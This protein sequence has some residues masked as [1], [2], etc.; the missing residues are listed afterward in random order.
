MTTETE[1]RPAETST[2]KRWLLYKAGK[3]DVGG[4]LIEQMVHQGL[5]GAIYLTP[6]DGLYWDEEDKLGAHWDRSTAAAIN[7]LTPVRVSIK[8]PDDCH[9]ALLML[10]AGLSRAMEANPPDTEQDFLQEA[11][12]FIMARQREILQ[13]RYFMAAVGTALIT[14][15]AAFVLILILTKWPQFSSNTISVTRDFLL[16]AIL[17]GVG[18][19]ISVS[20]RFRSIEVERYMSRRLASIG[21]C[22]RVVFGCCFGGVFLLFQK[23]GILLSAANSQPWFLAAAALVAGFSERAIPEVLAQFESQIAARKTRSQKPGKIRN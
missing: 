19:I 12:Q 2:T 20:Q 21:G 15:A 23:A 9:R 17:G 18:A 1:N 3:K 14:T 6:N 11:A 5:R 7:L 4:L 8:D 13:V 22:S 10:A 16:A